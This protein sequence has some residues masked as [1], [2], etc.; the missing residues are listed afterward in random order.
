MKKKERERFYNLDLIFTWWLY[1]GWSL[2]E[3]PFHRFPGKS[4]NFLP[5]LSFMI[6]GPN[7]IKFNNEISSFEKYELWFLDKE[8][9][10]EWDGNLWL[11]YGCP[12][13]GKGDWLRGLFP[14][15]ISFI[16]LS[17]T[18]PSKHPIWEIEMRDETD[19]EMIWYWWDGWWIDT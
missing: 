8:E 18:F 16:I 1:V 19:I 5:F 3:V 2:S 6:W 4:C 11:W 7:L 13:G 9:E 10:E 14:N 17:Y 12:M 15:S